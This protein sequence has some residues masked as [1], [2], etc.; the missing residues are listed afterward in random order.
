MQR[1][2]VSKPLEAIARFCFLPES[3]LYLEPMI[4]PQDFYIQDT[5]DLA[6]ALL[7]KVLHIRIGE[8]EEKARIVEV[9]AYLGVEDP[10]AHTYGDRRTKRTASMY[11][12]GGHS[13]VYLI[14]G[15]YNCLNVVSRTVDHPEA[16]L[17]RAVEPLTGVKPTHK[18]DLKTNGPGKL[19]KHY[20]ITKEHDGLRFWKKSSALSISD[21]GHEVDP[22]QIIACPRIGVDY[23]GEA[24]AW[25]LRFYIKDNIFVSKL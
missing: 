12:D 8:A 5:T 19:C 13:Y 20:G 14:Y 22:K 1:L 9:E 23:A 4:L 7:G 17:I 21:D 6:Q 2:S 18:K 15:M 16:I 11:L 25:P 24:A 3:G 10:A